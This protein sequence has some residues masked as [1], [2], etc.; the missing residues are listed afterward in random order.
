MTTRKRVTVGS[1]TS[2]LALAQTEEI[3]RPLRVLHPDTEFMIVPITTGGDRRKNAPLLSMARGMFVKEIELALL[4]R[5]IDFAVHSAKDLPSA[6]PD[7]LTLAAFGP[8]QDPR[9]VLVNRWGLPYRELPSGARIG[10]SSPRRT[11]QLK[12]YRPDVEILPIRGNVGTRVEKA[13]GDQYD[14]VVLAAA[15]LVRLGSQG[16]I[17]EYI[18]PDICIPDVGQGALAVEVRASDSDIV[19]MLA[20]VDHHATSTAVT[21]ER[22]FLETIGGG[23]QVPVAAYAQLDGAELHIS[24]MAAVPDGSEIYRVQVTCDTS[25][26]RLAGHQAAEALM[27]A[28]ARHIVGRDGR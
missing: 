12:A 28:G 21:A 23:C 3:L 22:A 6:L 20:G 13:R 4:N 26:P 24:T 25:E 17:S 1:R 18:S 5:E 7:G 16:E 9:D 10:T 15:G 11:A 8:R 2:P 27:D 14:G 19:G